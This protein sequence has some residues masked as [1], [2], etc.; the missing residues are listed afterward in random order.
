MAIVI[1]ASAPVVQPPITRPGM[2]FDHWRVTGIEERTQFM[3]QGM[4][5]PTRST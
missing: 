2:T 1:P 4:I 5:L 3:P